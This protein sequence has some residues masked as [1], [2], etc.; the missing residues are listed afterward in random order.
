MA[1]LPGQ[2]TIDV[3]TAIEAYSSAGSTGTRV[4]TRS[5]GEKSVST[6]PLERRG[7]SPFRSYEYARLTGNRPALGDGRDVHIVDLF[8]GC[9]GLGVGIEE[10]CRALDLKA[11]NTLAVDFD[12]QAAA[13]YEANLQPQRMHVGD[14]GALLDGDH[15]TEPTPLEEQLIDFVGD[16]DLLVGGP[17]CQGHST[18][19]NRSR[20]DDPR[21]ELY[22]KMV[23]FAEAA[24]PGAVIVEN[25]PGVVNDRR[26]KVVDLARERLTTLGYHVDDGVIAAHEIGVPQRRRRH[27]LLAHA[28][29]LVCIRDIADTYRQEAPPIEWAIDD[30]AETHRDSEFDR[31]STPSP[32]NRR[33]M[34]YLFEAGADGEQRYDLPNH[35]R[36]P[37]HRNGHTYPAV[38]G[39]MHPGEP[40]PTITSGFG[41][42]GQGRF[43]HPHQPRTLTPHEAAR[44]QGF[45]DWF[46][47]AAASTRTALAQM[48]GNAVPPRLAYVVALEMLR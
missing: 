35:L 13:V 1:P 31:P 16:V 4:V 44:I 28:D 19:N 10:A 38:Y 17:P 15:G 43:V 47:F 27:F 29:R 20:N 45:P 34:E 26:K 30:L 33:R 36:P 7:E 11:I 32:E 21:N 37:S 22:L 46:D 5:N 39:R 23:R 8:S 6:I 48:I 2:A 14:I 42:M 41:S 24:R 18:L 9:G 25:V 12:R 3:T 40:S